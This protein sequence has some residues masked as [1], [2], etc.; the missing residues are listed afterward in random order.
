MPS[1]TLTKG[2]SVGIDTYVNSGLPNNNYSTNI[3]IYAGGPTTAI[4]RGL[5]KFD[6]GLIPNDA[7]INSAS[8][9][10]YTE[11]TST[12][13]YA[14]HKVTKAWD[15]STTWNTS[16]TFDSNVVA[17]KT[18]PTSGWQVFDVR[19]LVQSWVNGEANHGFL[20][21]D[22]D[23]S[24]NNPDM[25][26]YSFD[27]T[28][29]QP[30]LTIDYTIPTTGKKQVEVVATS[31]PTASGTSSITIPIPTGS[32]AGDLLVAQ[33][34][35]GELN[36]I[37][38]PSGWTIQEHSVP[39]R[40]IV[41][42]YK[43]MQS[44]DAGATFSNS[45]SGTFWIGAMVAFRNVKNVLSYDRNIYSS[46]AS[47][48]TPPAKTTTA[49]NTLFALFNTGYAS[50]SFSTPLSYSEKYD[51]S[52]TAGSTAFAYHY[53]YRDKDQTTSEM[54]STLSTATTG[55]S[56][57]LVLEPIVNNPPTLTLSSPADNQTL[58][59][60]NTL[61]VQGSATDADS[62]NVV[63]V[64]YK[65]NS[66]T[67]R[68]LTSGVSDGSS[69]LSFAK[70]LTY[71]NKRIWDGSTDVTGVDLAENTNHILTIWS[72]DDQGGKSAEVTRMFK[73]IWNRPPA[74]D[75]SDTNLG[76]IGT[77]P[78]IN[79]TVTEPE[80]DS[81]TITELL[82][83]QQIRSF[84]GV[85]GQQNTATI[86]QDRW[87]RLALG[88]QH[89]LRIRATDSKGQ[90]ADRIYTFTRTETQIQFDLK[91]PFLC[92]AKPTRVLVT[93]DGTFP[94][95][96][97]VLVEVCNNAYDA[98]PA[99]EDATGPSLAGRGY[100]FTN[101]TKTAADWGINI[102]ITIN[103]GTATEKVILNGFGGAFD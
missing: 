44:G 54:T 90:F 9:S 27:S 38:M 15:N 103:K 65:I 48:F 52:G 56:S 58:A 93:L 20:L 8:L 98:V 101:E 85:A 4:K 30:T 51:S 59:E 2:N 94:D 45:G 60:G 76:A 67:T 74:I 66:G 78:S 25:S 91:N 47:S 29:S 84:S 46:N 17:S 96:S 73:V 26:F 68:A 82:N 83:G 40:K 80:S 10:L 72:E 86:D 71:S 24:T 95:G 64:K 12:R 7:I 3:Y 35:T 62:G 87:L 41:M 43:F 11:Y 32:Q 19:A 39:T 81:F 28:G 31:G 92:D 70:T 16:P 37:N 34:V 102:R 99:Y 18:I 97:T 6:L 53:M 75:G 79:Y 23:E 61:P 57:L 88:V 63:T 33:V 89:E 77:A 36:T 14:I 55:V 100:I 22:S 42:A 50:T 13:T 49:D 69:P 1:I 5:L 21:K